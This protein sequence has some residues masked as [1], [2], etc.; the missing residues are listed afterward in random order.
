[1]PTFEYEALDASG[2]F[3]RGVIDAETAR[4]ARLELR[5]LLLTPTKISSSRRETVQ[6]EALG[7]SNISAR[8]LANAT[9]QLSALVGA[10]TPLEEALNVVAT[11]SE[12]R[13]VQT[14][15]LAARA[16]VTEGWRFADALAERPKSFPSLYC[17]IIAAGETAGD[18]AGVLDRLA[19]M[20]EKNMAMRNKALSAL[21]YPTALIVI[22]TGIVVALLTQIVPKIVIQ[23]NMFEAELPLVTKFVMGVSA[24]IDVY[25]FYIAA[26]LLLGGIAFW[27]AMQ[28][29][30]FKMEIHRLLLTLPIIGKLLRGLDA[31]RFARTLSTLFAGG[32]PLLDCLEK[33][34]HT[35]TNSFMH[36]RLFETFQYVREG[37]S[38]SSAV[39]RSGVMPPM[40]A[41]MIAAGERSGSLPAMLDKTAVQLED[42]FDSIATT[43]LRLLEPGIILAIGGVIVVIV[44]AILLPILR[45]NS[46][47]SG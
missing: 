45:L 29:P 22:A 15:I 11:H 14:H 40:M 23:F 44:A 9:R 25:G 30:K 20:L 36:T 46:L 7:D 6:S 28:A 26:G 35:M 39:K 27:S 1:M 5:R 8:Q 31:A 4:M 19:V 2:R 34:A 33:A 16:R 42:E 37:A 47:V 24:F 38:L 13:A 10:G 12:S 18:L 17:A 3:R 43:A 32:A 41:P 21:I